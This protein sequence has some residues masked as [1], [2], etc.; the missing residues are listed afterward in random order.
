MESFT[1]KRSSDDWPER[2]RIP[3]RADAIVRARQAVRDAATDAGLRGDRIDNLVVAVSEAFTN[4]MEAQFR[5]HTSAPID[6][7][8]EM[9]GSTLEVQV[10]DHGDGFEPE[11]LP[12]RPPVTDPHHLDVERG[13]GIQLMRSLVDELVF[14]MTGSGMCVR[15]RMSLSRIG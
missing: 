14:D 2:I 3:V 8:C 4:A 1:R 10:R 7:V 6:V 12:P 13:W 9:T 5:A 15:L 11:S